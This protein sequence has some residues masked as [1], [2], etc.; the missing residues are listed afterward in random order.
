MSTVLQYTVEYYQIINILLQ[1]FFIS[2][3][4]IILNNSS[5]TVIST[6]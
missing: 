2:R 6:L 5:D 3:V 1:D 4:I